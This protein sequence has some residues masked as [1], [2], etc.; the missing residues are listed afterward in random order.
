MSMIPAAWHLTEEGVWK[1]DQTDSP[2]E[3]LRSLC[4]K[5]PDWMDLPIGVYTPDGSIDFVGAAGTAYQSEYGGS[6]ETDDYPAGTKILIFSA[7]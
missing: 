6:E 1:L 7:N 5:H 4:E 2:V 3:T